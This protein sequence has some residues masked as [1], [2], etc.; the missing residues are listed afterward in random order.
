M[1]SVATKIVRLCC[2]LCSASRPET[3]TTMMKL[4]AALLSIYLAVQLSVVLTKASSRRKAIERF[5]TRAKEDDKQ[6]SQA[7]QRV[8]RGSFKEN[9]DDSM[10]FLDLR[11]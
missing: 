5:P 1:A 10:M 4:A 3:S 9:D 8:L 2:N 6:R 7:R 11:Q